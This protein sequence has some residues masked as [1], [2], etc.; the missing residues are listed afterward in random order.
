MD[1]PHDQIEELNSLFDGTCSYKEGGYI[2]FYIADLQMPEGC[3]PEKVD[4]LLCPMPRDGYNS[5]L[6]FAEEIQSIKS[7][8]PNWNANGV[9]ILEKNWHAFSW[10]VPDNLRLSQMIAIHL[11]G[12]L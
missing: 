10:K 6:F 7:Q 8:K 9:R 3:K 1:I 11:K 2:Y 5:R 4:V 12:L